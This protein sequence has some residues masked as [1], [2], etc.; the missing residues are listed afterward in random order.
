MV[1]IMIVELSVLLSLMS[2]VPETNIRLVDGGGI[3]THGRVEIQINGTWGTICDDGFDQRDAAVI[4]SMMG[5]S[6]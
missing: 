3:P 1:M 2:A 4:C 5:F 6:R